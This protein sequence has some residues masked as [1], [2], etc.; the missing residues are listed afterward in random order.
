VA[1]IGLGCW[2]SLDRLPPDVLVGRDGEAIAIRLDNGQL[3]ALGGRRGAYE[4]ARW[5]EHDGDRRGA[6]IA[7]RGQG[8]RCDQVGCSA[9]VRDMTIAYVSQ[10]GSLTGTC[11]K[12][13]IVVVRFPRNRACLEGSII[14]DL[15]DLRRNGTHLLHIA[16][17]AAVVTTLGDYRGARPWTR[18]GRP[19]PYPRAMPTP[20]Q[21]ESRRRWF[22]R[23]PIQD[24]EPQPADADPW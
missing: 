6:A 14:I 22:S 15:A 24:R 5:L 21:T 10:P 17:G 12:A 11:A 13:D 2:K 20:R 4:I 19:A 18:S 16:G 3:S 1:A 23:T 7:A 9:R 8:F